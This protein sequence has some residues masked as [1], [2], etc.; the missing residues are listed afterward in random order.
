MPPSRRTAGPSRSARTRSWLAAGRA[1]SAS[2]G[3]ASSADP[4]RPGLRDSA[5]RQP[6]GVGPSSRRRRVRAP[7]SNMSHAERK[8][9]VEDAAPPEM[10]YSFVIPERERAGRRC[11]GSQ[12]PRP[13]D[14]GPPVRP[15]LPRADDRGRLL[16]GDLVVAEVAGAHRP[17]WARKRRRRSRPSCSPTAP[18][19]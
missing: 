11:D 19:S 5:R 4:G 7:G 2:C 12:P 6:R 16:L 18:R 1:S 15:A 8:G 17:G 14:P 10:P 13:R 3:G 9:R